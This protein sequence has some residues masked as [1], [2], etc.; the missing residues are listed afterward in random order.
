MDSMPCG[1]SLDCLHTF[2]GDKSSSL[3]EG[4]E[5][6]LKSKS[7]A[8]KQASMGHVREGMLIQNP[9]KI[10]GKAQSTGDLSQSTKKILA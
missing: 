7:H 1:N 5:T 3:G 8:F 2:R 10:G 6:A 4:L 9:A